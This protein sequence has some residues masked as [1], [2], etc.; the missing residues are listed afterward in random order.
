MV[1]LVLVSHSRPLAEAVSDLV[2][3]AVNSD[4][5]LSYCGGVGEDR[6]ELGTD[7]IE[8]Q[9]A[10]SSVYSDEGVL[11]LMDMGSA[12]LSAETAK[13]LLSPEQQEK[14]RLTSA[15]LVEGGVAA[16]VQAQ[17]GSSLDEVANAALQSL[18][19]KQD[20][21]QD[22][23]PGVQAASPAP[24]LSV[25]ESLEVTI[26][27]PHGLHLRPAAALIKALS[28]FPAEVF[29]ENRTESRGPVLARS[30]V[31]VAR[32]Q[33][34]Q[35]DTVRFSI[36]AP[37]PQP[38]I[39]AI[40]SLVESQFGESAQPVPPSETI[41]APDVSH[42]FGVSRGIAIG[43]PLRLDSIVASVPKYTLELPTEIAR[44]VASLRSAVA[45]AMAEFDARV[46]RLRT[47][48]PGY[49]LE[50]FH[51]QRML[52]ADPSILK[53]V[54]SKIQEQ[55]LNAAAAWHEILSRYAAEQEKADD[56]YLRARAADFREVERTVLA[57][58]IDDK[59]GTGLPD[60]A[61]TEPTIL[62]CEELTPTLSEQLRRLSIAGVIQLGGGTT[63]HGA[64]LARA[65]GIPAIG[66]ARKDAERLRPAQQVAINGSEGVLWIDPSP[67]VLRDLV[68][69]QQLEL[70]E[71]QTAFQKSHEPAITKDGISIQVGGNAGS[72]KDIFDARANGAEFIG[73]FRS[74]FLFQDFTEEPDEDQQL[75]AYQEALAP[76]AGSFPVTVRLLDI[77]GDKPLK[78]L[79]Q[80]KEANPFLGVRGVRLLMAN[81]RFF[82]SH[83]RA[84]L[85]LAVS[86]RV[87]LLIPMVTDSSEILATRKML[88]EI[89]GEL[90]KENMP[91][92]WPIPVGA[93]IETPSSGLLIDQLLPHLDFLSLGTNDLTQY[94]LC[95]ERGSASLSAF[96]DSLHPAVLRV[97]EQVI[98]A[99]QEHDVKASICGEIASDPEALPIWLALGLRDFSVT[100]AEIPATKSLIRKL[101]ISGIAAQMASKRLSFL[102]PLDVRKF[103]KTF[104]Q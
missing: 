46:D 14:V 37:D 50:I 58:L 65:L 26:Q 3:R 75:A 83:L 66:G 11:V 60:Q 97:C 93:M 7:A 17:L 35:G 104:I 68:G 103:S 30:L 96:S 59:G 1:G 21:V 48:L 98:R 99:A 72:A 77:G 18:L 22:V 12:I 102:G 5:Q 101:S 70:S 63:S 89:D 29:I 13:E 86:F 82:R 94:I 55:H 52:F 61:F 40:R 90:T 42:P 81:P 91:H 45:S 80:P 34:R 44:E 92:Q 23:S 69:R 54:Q 79:P 100:A 15:P 71:N 36:S 67:D 56:P 32:L 10:I 8:I 57:R 85:R 73:L 49:E 25:D 38:V 6:T 84:V 2:R 88:A 24:N 74:E 51:A 43:R 47:S 16:A 28:A 33:I 78:F 76:S 64:I 27:N 4:L 87:Q 19:P 95:A 20:Q 41:N 39:T 62:I 9:E 31:D 53:E